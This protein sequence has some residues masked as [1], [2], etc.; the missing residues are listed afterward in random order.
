MSQQAIRRVALLNQKSRTLIQKKKAKIYNGSKKLVRKIQLVVLSK[1][2]RKYS[3]KRMLR[4]QRF[5]IWW[6]I[7][8]C[9]MKVYLCKLLRLQKFLWSRIVKKKKVKKLMW[10][11]KVKKFWIIPCFMECL[12]SSYL[13]NSK[14]T[15]LTLGENCSKVSLFKSLPNHGI[16]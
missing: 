6:R 8:N 11:Y 16:C 9:L 13:R 1:V 7:F 5:K 10:L 12:K 14:P 15:V 4:N 2:I 3:I